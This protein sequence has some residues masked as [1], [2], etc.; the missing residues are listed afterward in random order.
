M[1]MVIALFLSQSS[2][3]FNKVSNGVVR[4][5]LE[6]HYQPHF[7]VVDLEEDIEEAGN[8]F[9]VEENNNY[10]SVRNT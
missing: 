3:T 7:E 4:I 10:Q 1:A 8:L 9:I 2:A 6:K 5:E